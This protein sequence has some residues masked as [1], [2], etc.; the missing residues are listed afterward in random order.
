MFFFSI[1]G[2][3]GGSTPIPVAHI[4]LHLQLDAIS[5][6]ISFLNTES[7]LVRCSD[8]GHMMILGHGTSE[9]AATR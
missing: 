2:N 9:I 4:S 3:L 8:S 6:I 7:T 1:E 5:S